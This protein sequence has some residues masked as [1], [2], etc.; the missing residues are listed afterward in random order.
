MFRTFQNHISMK[1]L[2]MEFQDIEVFES[3]DIL[4][5]FQDWQKRKIITA[6]FTK[7]LYKKSITKDAR[8]YLV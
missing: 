1:I 5:I 6:S 2:D 3:S 7:N 4:F 8:L